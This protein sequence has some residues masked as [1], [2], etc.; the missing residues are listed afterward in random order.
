MDA[1][2]EEDEDEGVEWMRD[3]DER[4]KIKQ[5]SEYSTRDKRQAVLSKG[6]GG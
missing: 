5:A 6:G 4:Q 3:S 1:R 2:S